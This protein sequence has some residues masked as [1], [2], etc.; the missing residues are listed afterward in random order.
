MAEQRRKSIGNKRY[1]ITDECRDIIVKAYGEFKKKV[2]TLGDKVC[3]SK[4][5]DNIDLGYY[6]ITIETPLYDEKGN[7]VMKGK[8][9]AVDTKKRDTENV[10][11]TEDI[12]VYF[13]REVK[14]YNKDAFIDKT[15]TK[16]GYEIPFTRYFYK[17]VAPEKSED[18]A[19]RI[20]TL[21]ADIAESLK[22]LFSKGGV[23]NG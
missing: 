11:L 8:K 3:E 12:D 19:N 2:Y 1:D 17:Y 6:K 16:V 9:T 5:I 7:I 14:P 4:L 13:E 20:Y 23:N 22:K 21:E 10:P 18:I 15:K